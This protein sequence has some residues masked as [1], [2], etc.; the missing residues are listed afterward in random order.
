VNR[1]LGKVGEKSSKK[2]FAKKRCRVVCFGSPSSVVILG[3]RKRGNRG[4]DE[5]GKKGGRLQRHFP[6]MG[7]DS[8]KDGNNGPPVKEKTGGIVAVN[9]QQPKIPV[10][11]SKL[12]I[13]LG[14]RGTVQV[15]GDEKEAKLLGQYKRTLTDSLRRAGR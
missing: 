9:Q 11:R 15:G 3:E 1:A 8:E 13:L 2:R 12:S 5:Q 7:Q 6:T 10:P 4:L 14:L